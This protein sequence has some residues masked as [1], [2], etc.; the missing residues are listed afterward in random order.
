[1]DLSHALCFSHFAKR[2][3]G[4]GSIGGVG[5]GGQNQCGLEKDL[6]VEARPEGRGVG[7]GRG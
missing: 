6:D 3:L 2:E 1:M 5:K 4:G 7:G